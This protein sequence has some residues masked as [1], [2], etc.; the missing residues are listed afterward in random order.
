[1]LIASVNELAAIVERSINIDRLLTSYRFLWLLV[2]I[3][4]SMTLIRI[5]W[6]FARIAECRSISIDRFHSSKL[7]TKRSN[8]F[9]WKLRT[10]LD[11]D[12]E[13]LG[14]LRVQ[15][16]QTFWQ[17]SDKRIR[18]TDMRTSENTPAP[19]WYCVAERT[20]CKFPSLVQRLQLRPVSVSLS[21]RQSQLLSLCVPHCIESVAPKM[22]FPFVLFSLLL[23]QVS[24]W[25]SSYG[26][27]SR[28]H[29]P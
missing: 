27:K 21:G 18:T 13:H 4:F 14:Q 15:T 23:S 25:P 16:L 28:L 26:G 5:W 1:M 3:A 24:T 12:F 20:I 7:R 11:T 9:G 19:G 10:T 2:R 22:L 6:N 17:T 8:N 29:L